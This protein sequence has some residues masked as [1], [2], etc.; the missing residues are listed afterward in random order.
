FT[1]G[2]T[3]SEITILDPANS[4]LLTMEDLPT[5]AW[6]IVSE[7]NDPPLCTVSAFAPILFV[8]Q[9][10]GD[11]MPL[12][13]FF[14]KPFAMSSVADTSALINFE[15]VGESAPTVSLWA[16]LVK[17]VSDVDLMT[18]E[19]PEDMCPHMLKDFNPTHQLLDGVAMEPDEE[20]GAGHWALEH[21][22][23]TTEV[24]EESYLLRATLTTEQGESVTVYSG[25]MFT[26]Y[27]P[28]V[29]LGQRPETDVEQAVDA[30]Q[31]DVSEAEVGPTPVSQDAATSPDVADAPTSG[32]SAEG[33]SGG[34]SSTPLWPLVCL[35]FLGY[36]RFCGARGALR[37]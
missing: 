21:S 22:W 17:R 26:V 31:T 24:S 36:G 27:H 16:G 6:S 30:D 18:I 25:G 7:T 3:L 37:F 11:P 33:C 10:E 1:D 23:D 32:G 8:V 29:P 4:L 12:G 35:I 20:K 14:A 2:E 19:N 28:E 13:G 9:H 34:R 5:G 15:A